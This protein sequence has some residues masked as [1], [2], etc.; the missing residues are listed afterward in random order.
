MTRPY[1]F[2]KR[3]GFTAGAIATLSIFAAP[4]TAAQ[5]ATIVLDF[6]GLQDLEP[7]ND[8]YNGG[9][10]GLGSVGQ[11]FGIEFS[12]NSLSIIDQDAGGTGNFGSEPSPDTIAFFLTGEAAVMNVA[13]GFDTGFSFFY[14]AI[15][16]PGVVNVYDDISGAGNLLTSIDLPLTPF[17]GD[18]DPTGQFSPFAP[19]GVN[20]DGTARSV[21]FGGTIDRI[22]FDNITLGSET[23][24]TEPTPAPID[25]TPVDPAPVDPAPVDPA[26]VDP[27]PTNPVPTPTNPAP[28][29][30]TPPIVVTPPTAETVPEPGSSAA[31]LMG[32]A[33]MSGAVVRRSRHAS[34]ANPRFS[35]C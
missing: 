30:V 26:P 15:N 4:Q 34:K 17:G 9:T 6:E 7:I 1:F 5:A 21:D 19:F 25:P 22:G 11:D 10:G 3:A 12:N 27:V 28:P 16:R 18:P 32:L 13:D 8:F 35:A 14:S 23:P 20:F 2:W 29:V 24:G 31:L 33:V